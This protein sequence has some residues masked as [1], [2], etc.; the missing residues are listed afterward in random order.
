MHP[1][2]PTLADK[3]ATAIADGILSGRFQFSDEK[4]NSVR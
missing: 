2:N 3:L 4:P 1:D